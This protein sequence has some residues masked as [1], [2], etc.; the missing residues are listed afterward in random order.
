M[1]KNK[2]LCWKDGLGKIQAGKEVEKLRKLVQQSRRQSLCKATVVGTQRSTDIN[3]NK[4]VI[5]DQKLKRTNYWHIQQGEGIWNAL[6]QWEKPD[7]K[8]YLIPFTCHPG[9]G[10]SRERKRISGCPPL[11]RGGIQKAQEIF[12]ADGNVLLPRLRW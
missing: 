9:K 8:G 10:K 5:D 2:L 6:C 3:I 4:N 11:G 1:R 12:W 7:S